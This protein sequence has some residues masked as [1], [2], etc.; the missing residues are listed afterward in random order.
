M[1]T[2]ASPPYRISRR[3]TAY[4]A[5]NDNNAQVTLDSSFPDA[6]LGLTGPPGDFFIQNPTPVATN[7]P[8]TKVHFFIPTGMFIDN[9]YN[10]YL[11]GLIDTTTT[12]PTEE[13]RKIISYEGSTR[14]AE[15]ESPTTVDWLA[16]AVGATGY[17]FV[18]RKE[19]PANIGNLVTVSSTTSMTLSP[20]ASAQPDFY[21][22]NFIRIITP[23]PVVNYS[24]FVSPFGEQ[25]LI[26]T[27]NS[28]TKA[29]TVDKPITGIQVGDGY[30]IESFSRDNCVPFSYNGSIVSSQEAVCYSV[31]LLNLVIPNFT[32]KSGRGGRPVFYPTMYLEFQPISS[33]TSGY[34][35][36]IYSNNPNSTRMLYR[37]L[38]SDIPAPLSSTFIKVDGDSMT[39]TIKFKPNDSFK[40]ALFHANGEPVEYAMDDNAP[41]AEPNPLVQI[42]ACFALFSFIS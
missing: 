28:V 26:K 7:T 23:V 10:N 8:N 39:H 6:Y 16:T 34:K 20:S 27:Y 33:A 5:F 2:T 17:A 31:E 30:E 3:I 22:G 9:Y 38:M 40:I 18:M 13:Y 19:I 42:S 41:P 1:N 25:R 15:L 12:P 24:T 36:I 35:N 4:E 11:L 21:V 29:I 37:I 14:L 32:L